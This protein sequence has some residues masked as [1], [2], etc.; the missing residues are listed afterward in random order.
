MF[1]RVWDG[2]KTSFQLALDDELLLV[3]LSCP[4]LFPD[5]SWLVSSEDELRGPSLELSE[6]SMVLLRHE[7]W[8][9]A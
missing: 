3:E 6:S 4:Q 1:R 7:E 2:L 9:G 5:E 8:G